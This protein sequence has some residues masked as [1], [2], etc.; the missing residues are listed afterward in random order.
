[1]DNPSFE[2]AASTIRYE[3]WI[4]RARGEKHYKSMFFW[5]GKGRKMR[6]SR[7]N[8]KTAAAALEYASK[9][10]QTVERLKGLGYL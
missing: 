9:F 1:M 10:N 5:T 6:F 7:K 4:N 3:K 2:W 8:S